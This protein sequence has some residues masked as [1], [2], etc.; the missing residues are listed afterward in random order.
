MDDWFTMESKFKNKCLLCGEEI[1]VG[2]PIQWKK[3]V[4]IK[5]YPP[6]EEPVQEDKSELIIIDND[7]WVDFTTYSLSELSKINN[8]QKCG[9]SLNGQ[10]D[11]YIN[12]DRR[13]C[14]RCFSAKV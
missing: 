6:C 7:E 1:Q 14:E 3:G 2:T 9:V 4:G 11:Q 5:H 13:T 12:M 8:C 10:K